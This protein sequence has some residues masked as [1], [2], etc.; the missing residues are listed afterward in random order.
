MPLTDPSASLSDPLHAFVAGAFISGSKNPIPLIA[1]KFEVLIAAGVAVVTTKRTFRNV[2]SQSIEATITFPVPVH[3]ALFRLEAHLDSRVLKARARN[4]L[5]ARE[6]YE[7]AVEGGKTAVLHEEVL[8]GVHML[9]VAHIAPGAEIEICSAWVTTLTQAKGRAS[10]RIPLTVGDIYGR[11]GL[12]DSDDFIHGGPVQTG[13]L[14]VTCRDGDVL[15]GGRRFDGGTAQVSIDMPIDLEVP[16]FAPSDLQ[17]IAADGRA[18]VVRV[19]PQQTADAALDIAVLV[20][21]SGSM[22]SAV[23]G[24]RNDLTKHAALVA[25]L[26]AAAKRLG[27]ADHI[28]LWQFCDM[29]SAVGSGSG[30]TAVRGLLRQLAD[31]RGGTEIGLALETVLEKSRAQD[32]LLVTDGKSHALDVQNLARSGRRF[33]VVLVGEDSLEANVGHLAALTGGEIFVAAG[34]D[35]ADIINAAFDSVRTP[36]IAMTPISGKPE[37]ISAARAGMVVTAAWLAPPQTDAQ[38][39]DQAEDAIMPR[40]VAALAACLALPALDPEAAGALAEAEG[41]V[42]H[43]TSLVLVDEEAPT[44]DGIPATRKIALP[45]PRTA[46][47]PAAMY[48]LDAFEAR[49]IAEPRPTAA[50]APEAAAPRAM[51]RM[52]GGGLFSSGPSDRMRSF[53]DSLMPSPVAPPPAPSRPAAPDLPPNL[54]SLHARIDWDRAPRRLQ[55]GDLSGL[56]A[57]VAQAIHRIADTDEIRA[58][59]AQLGLDPIILVIALLARAASRSKRS[60]RRIAKTILHGRT[61]R[62]ADLDAAVQQA[63]A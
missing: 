45:S 55:A 36:R 43:L 32:V 49:R 24:D 62:E 50:A 30:S 60:A 28:D 2:E 39:A 21:H 42:T 18:V 16:G 58:L 5:T 35:L 12:P 13:E 53:L 38:S 22:S 44:Q 15:L 37:R 10:L 40:A 31:T 29:P 52:I 11:S 26:D 6:T 4:R 17:G 23:S 8:R 41:L 46:A 1:T 34:V 14:A 19:A 63:Q 20:D 27:S 59:A 3:A 48:C 54:H 25:G 57:A 51:R 33:T 47:V 56:D 9:S 7:T 61:Y